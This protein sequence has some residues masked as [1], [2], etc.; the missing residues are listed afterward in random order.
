MK[1]VEKVTSAFSQ[2]PPDAFSGCEIKFSITPDKNKMTETG[3]RLIRYLCSQKPWEKYPNSE[4]FSLVFDT[5]EI[6]VTDEDFNCLF[7]ITYK[8]TVSIGLFE[9]SYDC[10][11]PFIGRDK[12]GNKIILSFRSDT[13]KEIFTEDLPDTLDMFCA[14]DDICSRPSY[15]DEE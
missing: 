1:V 14:W 15:D 5:D 2:L 13:C 7:G 12:R 9:T 11:S 6:K 10:Q 3:K 4:E 8:Q